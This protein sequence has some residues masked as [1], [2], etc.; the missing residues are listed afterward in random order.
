MCVHTKYVYRDRMSD[1]VHA[2]VDTGGVH[3]L[4]SLVGTPA[5]WYMDEIDIE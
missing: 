4:P 2:N 1:D 3:S 5:V